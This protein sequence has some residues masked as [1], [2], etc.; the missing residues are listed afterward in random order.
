MADANRS[1]LTSARLPPFG[2]V[3]LLLIFW[4]IAVSHFDKWTSFLWMGDDLIIHHWFQAG[5]FASTLWQAIGEQPIEKYRPVFSLYL[6]LSMSAFGNDISLYT[7]TNAFIH[8]LNSL[9]FFHI[10]FLV[11]K[12]RL[13]VALLS[14]LAFCW[15]RFALVQVGVA[16]GAGEAISLFFFLLS[17]LAF[18][19]SMIAPRSA[20]KWLWLA[21]I[22]SLLSVYT[23]E[24]YIL[25]PLLYAAA[26]WAVRDF[27]LMGYRTLAAISG[28]FLAIVLS[29]ILLKTLV[30]HM[31]FLVGAGS[32]HIGI[33]VHRTVTWLVE[34]LITIF[35]FNYGPEYLN[36]VK[37][38][39]L[40]IYYM[41][42]AASLPLGVLLTAAAALSRREGRAAIRQEWRYP[43]LFVLLAGA[44]LVPPILTIRL[45]P[46]WL[47]APF[48]MLLLCLSWGSTAASR[49]SLLAAIG[50][51]ALACVGSIAL[52]QMLS[53]YFDQ[54]YF[55][56]ATRFA[57]DVKR[58]FIDGPECKGR[59]DHHDCRSRP[60]PRDP[61]GSMVLPAIR[62][63]GAHGHLRGRC[64]SRGGGQ[65]HARYS[66]VRIPTRGRF[67]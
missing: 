27:R 66:G 37:I 23:Y 65:A 60:M 25:V 21:V 67:R 5:A 24:R 49:R 33:D 46:R 28:S 6:F 59:S 17:L 55:V 32:S 2:H 61:G 22:A 54:I 56:S 45:E 34:G 13:A 38:T 51:V 29:N 53:K 52:D 14:A 43:V 39:T 35:G 4:M 57:A 26:V 16:M 11:S 64:A 50:P 1:D 58:Q 36:A 48:A 41:F 8:A 19:Q 20:A 18:L 7:L 9:L 42:V 3:V 62:R 44:V 40:P 31:A 63:Q 30:L 47:L 10:A 15:S 12:K